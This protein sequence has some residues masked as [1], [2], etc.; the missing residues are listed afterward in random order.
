MQPCFNALQAK[1]MIL[2][3]FRPTEV[4]YAFVYAVYVIFHILSLKLDI[5]ICVCIKYILINKLVTSAQTVITCAGER[6]D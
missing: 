1:I 2:F 4:M 3:P 5:H 6:S